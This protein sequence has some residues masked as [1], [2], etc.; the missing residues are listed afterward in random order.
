ML[1]AKLLR[2]DITENVGYI[3]CYYKNKRVGLWYG[4]CVVFSLALALL[5]SLIE[6]GS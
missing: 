5:I 1:K 4:F 2:R 3:A 6:A